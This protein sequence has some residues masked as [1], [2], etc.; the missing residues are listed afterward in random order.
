MK[1]EIFELNG[2]NGTVLP[3]YIWLPEGEVKAFLQ[4]THG[5]TEQWGGTKHLQNFFTLTSY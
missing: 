5:M 1:T 3:A 2:H 4:V